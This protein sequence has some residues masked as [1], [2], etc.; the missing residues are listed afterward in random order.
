[1]VAGVQ[2]IHRVD[3]QQDQGVAPRVPLRAIDAELQL[4]AAR[5]HLLQDLVDR[6]LMGAGPVRHQFAQIAPHAAQHDRG[7]RPA[8]VLLGVGKQ[9][10]QI[11]IIHGRVLRAVAGPL[12]FIMLTQCFFQVRKRVDLPPRADKRR[13]LGDFVHQ[14][15]DVVQLFQRRPTFVLRSPARAGTQP[16]GKRLGE[17]FR[18]MALRVPGVQMQHVPL[19]VRFGRV[20]LRDRAPS[21]CRTTA[22][23]AGGVAVDRRCRSRVRLHAAGSAAAIAASRLRR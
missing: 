22:A 12:L 11:A 21:S 23:S 1:M 6:V 15:V 14:L 20:E 18:R 8:A 5:D 10:S 7:R 17:I 19:A 16:D 13:F 3:G 4:A 2:I 9:S